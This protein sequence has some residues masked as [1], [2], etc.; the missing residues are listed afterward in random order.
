[1]AREQGLSEEQVTEISDNYEESDLSPR[2]KAAIA[3]TDAIIG[4]PRQVSPELQRRLREHFSDP[5]IVE[6][7][8]GVGL[9]MS[10][11]KVL[12]TLGMEPEEMTTEIVPTPAS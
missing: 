5:E 4:D 11:S 9:F 6:M 10:L 12:I 7:A 1:M 8:L 3:F 2:D